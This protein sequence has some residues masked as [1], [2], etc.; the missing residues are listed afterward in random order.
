MGA[1]KCGWLTRASSTVRVQRCTQSPWFDAPVDAW[2]EAPLEAW[3][4]ASGVAV[5][6]SLSFTLDTALAVFAFP[7]ACIEPATSCPQGV[8]A[9][10]ARIPGDS[11]NTATVIKRRTLVG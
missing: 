6:L 2:F 1:T 5:R 4:D 8:S 7:Q 11:A 10:C 3:F 9:V